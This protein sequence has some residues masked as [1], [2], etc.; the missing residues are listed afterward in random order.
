MTADELQATAH[1]R[2]NCGCGDWPLAYWTNVDADPAVPADV[3]GDVIEYLAALPADTLEQIWA[4]HFLE[5]LAP[6][7]AQEFLAQCW[8]TL[9]PGGRLGIVVPDTR[10]IMQRWLAGA[11]DCM[12]YPCGVYHAV[13][14]LDEVCRMFLYSNVQN[15]PHRWSYDAGTL[16]R[17]LAQNG[18]QD[19]APIDRYRDQR[20]GSGQWYQCGWDGFK[21]AIS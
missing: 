14:D 8:R 6:V 20:L 18:F 5:H 9:Q 12:E 17:L 11:I 7:G 3:H 4:C 19:L 10:E 1:L 16:R 13:A 21:C 15:P 2:I